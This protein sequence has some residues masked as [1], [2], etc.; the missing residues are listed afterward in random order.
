MKQVVFTYEQ[1]LYNDSYFYAVFWHEGKE[2]LAEFTEEMIG[3]TAFAGGHY[4]MPA[5]A[6][7]AVKERYKTVWLPL[8]RAY[9]NRYV[10]RKGSLV[11]AANARKY[12]STGMVQAICPDKYDSRCWVAL[13]DFAEGSTWMNVNKL[14]VL[15][16]F[17][18]NW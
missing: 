16:P 3:S 8:K 17:V 12:K 9:D 4:D 6:S 2:G 11:Y 5:T 1:N 7:D 18:H 13:V 14:T 10:A 15:Q